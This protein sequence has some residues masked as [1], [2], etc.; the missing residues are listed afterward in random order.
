MDTKTKTEIVR[1]AELEELVAS[2]LTFKR[3][4][5]DFMPIMNLIQNQTR[6]IQKRFWKL[7]DAAIAKEAN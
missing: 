5:W 4:G 6:Y 7:A 2:Y 1:L 3:A